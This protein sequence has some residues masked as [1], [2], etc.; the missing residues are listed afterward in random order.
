[1]AKKRAAPKRK[2][3]RK[4]KAPEGYVPI[5][6]TY[7]GGFRGP[8]GKAEASASKKLAPH[9]LR[10]LQMLGKVYN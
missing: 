10:A 2:A 6:P 4:R 7:V 5:P 9:L 3:P 1:M 8:P